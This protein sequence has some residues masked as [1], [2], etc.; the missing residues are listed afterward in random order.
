ML[1]RQLKI[2]LVA[3]E[4]TDAFN[5]YYLR[6]RIIKAQDDERLGRPSG[7]GQLSGMLAA[8][9]AVA[10]LPA[11]SSSSQTSQ[12]EHGG[13]S[14][15]SLSRLESTSSE[16]GHHQTSGQ[17]SVETPT[18]AHAPRQSSRL[19]LINS[20]TSRPSSSVALSSS[21][22]ED[23][24][25]IDI[26]RRDQMELEDQRVG[27]SPIDQEL[28]P[29][30]PNH[31]PPVSVQPAQDGSKMK[32]H[33]PHGTR[34][35]TPLNSRPPSALGVKPSSLAAG[36]PT[37]R[38]SRPSY[39]AAV[40]SEPRD[41]HLA[42]SLGGQ[43]IPLDTTVYGAVY[44]HD[45]NN[46]EGPVPVSNEDASSLDPGSREEGPGIPAS[47]LEGLQQ[48]SILRLLRAL[49]GLNSD[50]N[51][52][53]KTYEDLSADQALPE[54]IFIN[55]KLTAKLNQ[56]LEEPMIVASACLPDWACDLPQQFPFLF[57]FETSRQK[58]L[59]SLI[60][61]FELYSSCRAMLEVEYFDEVGTGPTLEF[62]SL[63]SMVFAEQQYMMWR[64]HDS[65]GQS[66]DLFSQNS[67][68]PSPMDKHSSQSERGIECLRK[69]KV[70][71]QFMAKALMDSRIVDL[72]VSRC[73][74]QLILDYKLPLT[75][76]SV[77]LHLSKYFV[78]KQ[79]IEVF[80]GLTESERDGA[81]RQ[82]RVDGAKV[83]DLAVEFALPGYDIEM[84]PD[85]TETVVAIDNVKMFK[86]GLSMLGYENVTTNYAKEFNDHQEPI[87]ETEQQ[88][89]GFMKSD[90]IHI[91]NIPKNL[92]RNEIEEKISSFKPFQQALIMVCYF[93]LPF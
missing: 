46:V 51:E 81:I 65:G 49:H 47:I 23:S 4:G 83:E 91:K 45:L 9:A 5:D 78:M 54:T 42:F 34:I 56:Q 36:G 21:A 80:G 61:V 59:E 2:R 85:G 25:E 93:F 52:F 92:T 17:T 35:S 40:K 8:F 3:A 7:S 89:N 75:I 16:L 64:N 24:M 31:D 12:I 22:P 33:T 32:A 26:T 19:S 84:K 62:F 28:E 66:L 39:A 71:G 6:P 69:F 86:P 70:L 58:I 76:A 50:W 20:S 38:S 90:I 72:S 37:S 30:S 82:I 73:F 88:I 10:G 87:D 77:R 63:A 53:R 15:P 29:R 18:N 13:L 43:S 1:A 14:L 11:T 48:A 67:P 79:A 68:F 55:N 41:W 27:V 57:P 60:K 74:A 44:T